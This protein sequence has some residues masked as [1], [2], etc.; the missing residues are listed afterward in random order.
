MPQSF[1]DTTKWSIFTTAY[2]LLLVYTGVIMWSRVYLGVHSSSQVLIGGLLG[3]I[4]SEW[5]FTYYYR[6][7]ISNF[8]IGFFLSFENHYQRKYLLMA[9]ALMFLIF[10]TLLGLIYY[11][12]L[13]NPPEG[14]TEWAA[15]MAAGT[16]G[17]PCSATK[18][19]E[20]KNYTSGLFINLYLVFDLLMIGL[21]SEAYRYDKHHFRR[22]HWKHVLLRNALIAACLGL[23][24]LP[25]LM[26]KPLNIKGDFYFVVARFV[27]AFCL[28]GLVVYLVPSL[29][30][31]FNIGARGGFI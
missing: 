14:K 22:M 9:K 11:L 10:N 1:S 16:C 30:R 4:L 13:R 8:S 5:F 15:N 19:F 20:W 23:A 27:S 29:Y 12:R 31:T 25:E 28:A 2:V 18:T 7:G 24:F 21:N 3:Y 26:L 6:K 17:K